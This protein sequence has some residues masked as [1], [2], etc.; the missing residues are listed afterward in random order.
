MEGSRYLANRTDTK[1]YARMRDGRGSDSFSSKASE[2]VLEAH[3]FR[4]YVPA[5][6]YRKRAGLTRKWKNKFA[7]H[8]QLNSDDCHTSYYRGIGHHS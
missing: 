7:G 2:K 1:F 6:T 3:Y 5:N 4:P 8:L